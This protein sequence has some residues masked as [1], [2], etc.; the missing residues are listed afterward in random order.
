MSEVS[1]RVSNQKRFGCE[2]GSQAHRLEAATVVDGER[3]FASLVIG[4]EGV[5]QMEV[6]LD[7]TRA[8]ELM[9]WLADH[10]GLRKGKNGGER[11]S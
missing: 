9:F 2:C 8:R 11:V 1:N 6:A 4:F 7:E 10:L 3:R 5:G